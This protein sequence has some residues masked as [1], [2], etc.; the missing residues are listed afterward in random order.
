MDTKVRVKLWDSDSFGLI[1]LDNES[2]VVWENQVGGTCCSQQE[3]RG[4]FVPLPF[5]T[6]DPSH[7]R[8]WGPEQDTFYDQAHL[9]YNENIVRLA[10]QLREWMLHFYLR[11]LTPAEHKAAALGYA[12]KIFEAWLPVMID[13]DCDSMPSQLEPFIGY[14]AILTYPNSD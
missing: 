4:F 7:T 12:G 2:V 14:H 3:A 1:V 5:L 13:K 8:M 9:D 6:T 11:A 10:K